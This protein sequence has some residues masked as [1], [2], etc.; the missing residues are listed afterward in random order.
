MLI[1]S[2]DQLMN[3][4]TGFDSTNVLTMNLPLSPTKIKDADQAVQYTQRVMNNV[5][6]F[7]GSRD[8]LLA[9]V[10]GLG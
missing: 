6:A 7:P 4:H 2:F 1:R 10:A 3:V 9:A 5:G 8:H